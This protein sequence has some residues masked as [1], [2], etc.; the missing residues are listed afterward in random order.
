MS[1]QEIAEAQPEM[2]LNNI[3]VTLTRMHEKGEIG[4]SERDAYH[5]K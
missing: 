4:K 5:A 2:T 1:V 3:R